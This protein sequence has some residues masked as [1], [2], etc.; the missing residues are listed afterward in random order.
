[1]RLFRSSLEKLAPRM[2]TLLTFGLLAGLLVLIELAVATTRTGEGRAS[3]NALTL[4]TFP[5]AYDQ[6]LRFILGLGGLFAVTYGAAIAGSE[7][8]WGTL[9]TAVARG[10]SRSRYVLSTFAAIALVLIVGL[11]VAFAIG[12][13]GAVIGSKIAAV[14]LDGLSDASV[15]DGLPEK[16]ARGWISITMTAS[17][18]FAI[19]TLARSQLAGIGAGI[20]LY[21]GEAF[22]SI[23]LPDIVQYLPFDLANTAVGAGGGFGGP[24]APGAQMSAD[25]ALVLVV[26]WLIGSL[27]V[28]AGFTERAEITG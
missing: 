18:G 8:T 9:K 4:I 24:G 23:F 26:V 1:M 5:G 17:V 2:A 14:S 28:A 27:A 10:E 15:L 16:F 21:F 11:L 13:A 25:T 3:R 19:A 12:A 22:A 20:A 6:I 7:W